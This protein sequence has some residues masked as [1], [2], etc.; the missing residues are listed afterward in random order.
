MKNRQVRLRLSF[1]TIR[2]GRVARLSERLQNSLFG[3][4]PPDSPIGKRL[5]ECNFSYLNV[6]VYEHP[7][8]GWIPWE[9][10]KHPN[11][12]RP[13]AIV[14]TSFSWTTKREI[15]IS[16]NSPH[17][18][19]LRV[20]MVI[21]RPH[22][23]RDASL[24]SIANHILRAVSL[25]SEPKIQL[26]VLR[27]P[28]LASLETRL[29][30]ARDEGNPYDAVH[31][32][33]HC[34][35]GESPFDPN[36][37]RGLLHFEN[38]RG[39][40]QKISGRIIG[41][42]LNRARVS[43]FLMNACR[44]GY[45]DPSHTPEMMT[46]DSSAKFSSVADEIHDAGIPGVLGMRYD[47]YVVTG[48]KFFGDLY[49][50]LAGGFDL[51]G[52]VSASRAR[53]T[54]L[55]GKIDWTGL[56][57][58]VPYVIETNCSFSTKP[59]RIEWIN[60]EA[61]KA[62]PRHASVFEGCPEA[63]PNDDQ[64]QFFGRDNAFHKLEHAASGST[65]TE[66]T[67][68]SGIGKSELA[69]EFAS[70]WAL[71]STPPSPSI[72]LYANKWSDLDSFVCEVNRISKRT[73][74]SSTSKNRLI[75]I[76]N[77]T[78][79]LDQPG[80]YWPSRDSKRFLS[81]TQEWAANFG[82][83]FLTGRVASG[84]S[85]ITRIPL[86]GLEWDAL[87]EM[88]TT[89]CFPIDSAGGKGLLYW[90]NGIP[91]VVNL[92]PKLCKNLD[93]NDI[94]LFQ[95]FLLEA[96]GGIF[97]PPDLGLDLSN[98]TGINFFPSDNLDGISL[99][100]AGMLFQGHLFLNDWNIFCDLCKKKG[101][102][103]TGENEPIESLQREMKLAERQGLAS[104]TVHGYF[105]HPLTPFSFGP[106]YSQALTLISKG[107]RKA[108]NKA[109]IVLLS[110]Y[111]IAI[112]A[113]ITLKGSL[114]GWREAIPH[115]S[116][117]QNLWHSA[118]L[119]I[120]GQ[121][122]GN[123]LPLLHHLREALI[124]NGR[125][126]EWEYTLAEVERMIKESPP[127]NE[128]L[129]YERLDIQLLRLRAA[130]AQRKGQ[131]ELNDQLESI[132]L[133]AAMADDFQ[134]VFGDEQDDAKTLEIGNIRKAGALLK[135]G[136]IADSLKLPEC[137]DFYFEALALSENS[138]SRQLNIILNIARAHLNIPALFDLHEYEKYSRIA[139][140]LAESNSF[141]G[142]EALTRAKRSLGNALAELIQRGMLSGTDSAREA[143][144]CLEFSVNSPASSNETQAIAEN[145][146]GMLAAAEGV[147]NDAA[148]HFIRAASLF[149][150]MNDPAGTA[151]SQTNAALSYARLKRKKESIELVRLAKQS[152]AGNP[153]ESGQLESIW[154]AIE[155]Q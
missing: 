88:S 43:W 17:V 56:E 91:E 22:R 46:Q 89:L 115:A 124:L 86:E 68:C 135:H 108:L 132:R 70:W 141:L 93:L 126:E 137:L 77:G 60:I 150:K 41:K 61:N 121:A 133:A 34:T 16:G 142:Q 144:A 6:R 58:L 37:K 54:E 13:L 117:T 59:R 84:Q 11:C 42:I 130:E 19:G 79:I 52:A 153:S 98:D 90:S 139:V 154:A 1:Y 94:G 27:P 5:A 64:R 155:R 69:L 92:L 152:L 87:Y 85:N 104:P 81:W 138:P 33:G 10:L 18:Q 127:S 31:F 7:S 44:S 136:E 96:M 151:S 8:A 49:S 129:G 51:S 21:C 38:T 100:I 40:L 57:W 48:A 114:P 146:L 9:L 145:G 74:S 55:Q 118:Q 36:S 149:E 75:V 110:S 26:D 63:P 66:I 107:D 39:E 101:L 102:D 113:A 82:P 30:E 140:D 28:T 25:S 12:E 45:V 147:F 23:N 109:V 80:E 15:L 111:V 128:Q 47:L 116:Q 83:V 148:S 67:G 50:C 122:W 4:I 3:C 71:T 72:Y 99:I 125:E 134:L 73:R 112:Q 123:T 131:I 62:L 32:D 105:L 65:L 97:N 103:F 120:Q 119:G 53:T 24:R 143:K 29:K 35:W 2:A 95:D 76:E 78:V 106:L 20:L 14:A